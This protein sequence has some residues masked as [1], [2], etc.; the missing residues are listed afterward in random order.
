ML[1][2]R[3]KYHGERGWKVPPN[4]PHRQDRD[5]R[6]P[7]LGLPGAAVHRPSSTCSPSRWPRSAASSLPRPS[8]SSSPSPSAEPAQARPHRAADEGPL[9]AGASGHDQPGVGGH[10]PRRRHGHHARRRQPLRAEV[11]A[12]PHQHRRAGCGGHQ[13]AH[14][15]RR[16]PGVPERRGA[17]LQRARADALHQGGLGG[18]ELRQES[19]AAGGSRRRCL[20]R[21]GAGRQLAR[22]R[23][24]R[25][26][27]LQSR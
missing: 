19:L 7:D 13:R 20:R 5:S 16:R 25:L 27:R 22:S 17:E 8:S 24:G 18:R 11:D 1:V 4:H 6:R 15:G 21:A 14:D 3:W 23:F 2:L 12:G 9:P 10:P 26:R